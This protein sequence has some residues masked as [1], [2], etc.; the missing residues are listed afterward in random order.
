MFDL[1]STGWSLPPGSIAQELEMVALTFF[2]VAMAICT[3]IFA[4]AFLA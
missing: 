3:A 2:L 1:G 4:L